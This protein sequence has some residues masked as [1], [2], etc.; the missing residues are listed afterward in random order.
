MLDIF[1]M[2]VFIV[3]GMMISLAIWVKYTRLSRIRRPDTEM[4]MPSRPLALASGVLDRGFILISIGFAFLFL[5]RGYP[6][7]F[8]PFS[9]HFDFPI[10][11]TGMALLLVGMSGAWWAVASLGE[12]NEPRW[13]HLKQG[14]ALVKTGAYRYVRHPQ[15]ASKMI[16]YLGLF[17][18]FKDFLF[19]LTFLSSVLLLYLQA[20]SEEKL[21]I[22]LFGEEYNAYQTARGMFFPLVLGW[23]IRQVRAATLWI[24]TKASD[25]F[26]R[27]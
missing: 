7:I 4:P 9:C 21:L 16:A 26:S 17:L 23:W 1:L 27:Y 8:L 22:Q 13:A 24:G 10:Q 12:F 18:F 6:D 3:L 19:L 25:K 20:K 5:L 2:K 15:Y 11:L 14:H